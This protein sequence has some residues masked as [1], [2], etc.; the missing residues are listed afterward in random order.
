MLSLVYIYFFRN[1][2]CEMRVSAPP[3]LAKPSEGSDGFP[4]GGRIGV[5]VFRLGVGISGIRPFSGSDGAARDSWELHERHLSACPPNHSKT[6]L[7]VIFFF[8]LS[9][10]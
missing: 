3:H 8:A 2:I 6:R 7:G 9:P 4:R 1:E 5:F 10:L